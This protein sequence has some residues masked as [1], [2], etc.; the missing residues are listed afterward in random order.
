MVYLKNFLRTSI[1]SFAPL[2]W[3]LE[4]IPRQLSALRFH[5][6]NNSRAPQG[7]LHSADLGFDGLEVLLEGGLTEEQNLL[8]GLASAGALDQFVVVSA[9]A[10]DDVVGFHKEEVAGV[11]RIRFDREAKGEWFDDTNGGG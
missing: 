10:V 4:V 1:T 11:V 7:T 8:A 5:L 9:N 2:I 6:R 3:G